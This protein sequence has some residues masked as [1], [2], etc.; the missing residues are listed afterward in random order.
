MDRGKAAI[1]KRPGKNKGA[2]PLGD[3]F[4]LGSKPTKTT[5]S[6]LQKAS[7]SSLGDKKLSALGDR[8]R[9]PI[10]LISSGTSSKKPKLLSSGQTFTPLG[11]P[12]DRDAEK[13]LSPANLTSHAI[14][15]NSI[16]VESISL[17]REVLSAE[18]NDDYDRV[19][20]LLCGAV[21]YLQSNRSKPDHIMYLSLMH[22]AKCKPA[23]FNYD[24]VIE[25]FCFLLKRDLSLNFKSKGNSL[26]SVLACN[27]LMKAFSD[28]DNWPDDFV[29]VY[30]E[31]A[32]GERVWVD[33]ADCKGFVDNIITA[34]NTNLPKDVV[35]T[36]DAKSEHGS[37]SP[38]VHIS[39][40][41]DSKMEIDTDKSS[42]TSSSSSS[43]DVQNVQ[44][45]QRFQY[46]LDDIETSTMDI[47]H[48]QIA[49][50]QLMDASS[51][52]LIKLLT[53]TCGYSE[54]RLRAAQTLEL[55]LQ[56]PKLARASQ[57]LLMSVCMNCNQ[58]DT[59]SDAE[60]IALLIKMR[61]KTKPLINHYL[62]C[63]RELLS[64][65]T[66][67]L[68]MVLTHTIYN[69][70]STTRNPNNMA[71][72]G[73][74]FQTKPDEAAKI[75]A[76]VFQDLL[77]NKDDYLRAL[78]A[79]FREIVRSLRYDINFEVFCLA[80]MKDKIGMFKFNEF[81]FKERYM[82]SVV[83][84]VTMCILQAITPA[85]REAVTALNRGDNKDIEV[86]YKYQDLVATIQ[87]D[88][89]WW[90]HTLVTEYLEPKPQEYVYCLRKLLFMESVDQYVKDNWPAEADRGPMMR[91]A[92]ECPVL[93]DTL[94]R[95]LIIGLN[96]ELA[97]TPTE[98]IE[99]ADILIRRAALLHTEGRKVI[100]VERLELFDALLN[101]CSYKHPENIVLPAGYT[102]PQLAISNLYWKAWQILLVIGA[103]N[104]STFGLA[105]WENYPTLKCMI[106]MVMTSNYKF[107]PPTTAV[108]D[109]VIEEIRSKEIQV[110]Q[111]EKQEILEFEGHLA[112][113]STKVT[114]TEANSLL[115][116]QLTSM[117]PNDIARKPPQQ[118]MDQL[119]SLNDSLKIGQILCRSRNP[120]FLLDIIQ[121]QGTSQS[122][123]WLA[124]LVESSDGSL[125]MLP[126]QCLCE[127][128]LHETQDVV[129][130]NIE[131]DSL[132]FEK[133][134]KSQ[135]LKKQ[136]QLLTHL[137]SLVHDTNIDRNKTHEVMDYF[138]K[139]LSSTQASNRVLA[140]KGM[141]MIISKSQVS[142][143]DECKTM[144]DIDTSAYKHNWLLVDLPS[145]PTFNDM[146]AKTCAALR[147]AIQIEAD[148]S[149]V[150][151]YVI[152]L[153][154]HT[155]DST[156][157]ELDELV[158]DIAQLIVERTT[159]INY[160]LPQ[161]VGEISKCSLDTLEA[162]IQ[163][164]VD[165][166]RKAKEPNKTGYQWSNT[167][168]QIILQWEKGES[169]TMRIL[170]V[171]AMII[172]LSYGPA[173]DES[174]YKEL[175][176]TWF[177]EEGKP[178]SAF[179]LDTSEEALMHPDWLKLRMIRSKSDPLIDAALQ[180][181]E[182]NQL[183]LFVQSFGIPVHSMSKLLQCLDNAVTMD[184]ISIEQSGIDKTYMAQVI[185]VQHKRG[186]IGGDKFYSLITDGKQLEQSKDEEAMETKPTDDDIWTSQGQGYNDMSSATECI[187]S[188]HMA[189]MLLQ[190]FDPSGR[191]SPDTVT[192]F[193]SLLMSVNKTS[194]GALD[195]IEGFIQVLKGSSATEFARSII[196]STNACSLLRIIIAKKKLDG[197]KERISETMALLAPYCVGQ[198]TPMSAMANQYMLTITQQT[199]SK[200]SLRTTSPHTF[201]EDVKEKS[202]SDSSQ[203]ETLVYDSL[204][205]VSNDVT[206]ATKL[207]CNVLTTQQQTDSKC[208]MLP[209]TCALF[210]DWL[211][212]LD[213]EIVRLVP[214]LQEKLIFAKQTVTQSS[215]AREHSSQ[216][217]L[218][219]LLTHQSS[220][221]TLHKCINSL[222]DSTQK[223]YDPVSVLD[224]LWACIHVP[225]IWQGRERTQTKNQNPE[226]VLCLKSC[227]LTVL[228]DYI[229]QEAISFL[230]NQK[231]D[232]IETESK[233]TNQTPACIRS[234]I[235]LL[236]ACICGDE[237][238]V[239]GLVQCIEKIMKTQ[240]EKWVYEALLLELYLQYPYL[241]VWLSNMKYI[242][243]NS[244]MSHLSKT[245][246]DM[247]T[248]RLITG[249]YQGNK[250]K[251][252]DDLMSDVNIACRKLA[253]EHPVL[254]LRQLP[255]IVAL[256]KGKTQFT[257]AEFKQRNLF[258][259]YTYILGILELLQPHIFDKQHSTFNDIIEE[260]FCLL[261]DYGSQA[262]G[263]L[264]PVVVKLV[265]MLN[266]Y[267]RYD[268]IRANT[269]LQKHVLLLS[270]VSCQFPDISPLMSLLAGLSIPRVSSQD[271]S[272]AVVYPVRPES[273]WTNQLTP[274][275]TKIRKENS[276]EILSML[277]NLDDT[278]KRKV[279][280]LEHFVDDFK[281]LMLFANDQCRNTTF[282]L[283][284]RHLKQ[285]LRHVDEFVPIFLQCLDSENPDI[286]TTALTNLA[287]F[288]L[289][290]QNYA[291]VILQK[292][293]STGINT[294]IE[295]SSYISDSLQ[296][297]NLDL[298]TE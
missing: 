140:T 172:M 175:L 191:K 26:V 254:M 157:Q 135:K 138:L 29:K 189:N 70:L 225:K 297:L 85:V 109:S 136:Q 207:A 71:L 60:V 117:A 142:P 223:G 186:A 31:D 53:V 110:A 286:V 243:S 272:P 270:Q 24:V 92:T 245:Q 72:I 204:K 219:A 123:P 187:P 149:L 15:D 292:A 48:E 100:H 12:T 179:L 288:T 33:R 215:V 234:R 46:Q 194:T 180:D 282:E 55:W 101:L 291:D 115:I 296:L 84:L 174:L 16:E 249:L 83:D 181:L 222:L 248:H 198:K 32:L 112:A 171:N 77:R 38:I 246:M 242:T 67:N 40:D 10:S 235:D 86:I 264:T 267:V 218:L 155:T 178:P 231:S 93:E 221:N 233:S 197:I 125:D 113:S 266:D 116:A 251:R 21:K 2:L 183:F 134:K 173:H 129:R 281:R 258:S 56:N 98:S 139:R 236:R 239:I 119:R 141:S 241:S 199:T 154:K 44:I 62:A 150:S 217:Y 268:S 90:L 240:S 206:M 211:E 167:Q 114:I 107:P 153:A 257:F 244:I 213:P 152:Y 228:A 7:S 252:N 89:V 96:R 88:G 277:Q 210:I 293:L 87:R 6:S 278:S 190:A 127:F 232:G 78:R 193:K 3:L 163:L 54:V 39:E 289:L 42:S 238:K 111:K 137:Q 1:G 74:V 94:M 169:A 23:L 143:T 97:L 121:R 105:A 108:D 226:D 182:P 250:S 287:E 290:C 45:L 99:L 256:L 195:V 148:P 37:A 75:L 68:R 146:K 203:L 131:D 34:F 28:E 224:F 188:S 20:G 184:V 91:L 14:D 66:D 79:L 220:W 168:D 214:E 47:I 230:A 118:V 164:F 259:L 162:F 61:M 160:I 43:C 201:L 19:E 69:E 185:E 280:V 274:I 133:H 275:M 265:Q 192:H 276:D 9:E 147:Q 17:L 102:P 36:L 8:K 284:K 161:D 170:V 81:A 95:I 122:M 144:M 159:I 253:A 64:Q 298:A 35:T 279:E 13:R 262:A 132:K 177:P 22:L 145:L 294:S 11:R 51:K 73:V 59:A 106:E 5:E 57:E 130:D 30:I 216:P 120:D 80:L 208:G 58:C 128:L 283:V 156:L 260:Y 104:P 18:E 41:D 76:S 63:I 52:T 237:E 273:P 165:Y 205:T 151:A 158:V 103:F 255:A 82:V 202:I 229:I 227:Q 196:Q 166:L 263:R 50:R 200:S 247:V 25:A 49:K 126:V 124:E 4:A 65:H 209:S 176:E 261:K 295:T 269:L 212:L 27:V 285:S 271:T